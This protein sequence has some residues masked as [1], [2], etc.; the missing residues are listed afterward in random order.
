[1]PIILLGLLNVVKGTVL[2]MVV[3]TFTG[4][5]VKF[6]IVEVL[7]LLVRKYEIRAS[8]T[9]SKEDDVKAASCRNAL[10]FLKK[11]WK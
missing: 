9:P 1:M 2:K 5:A 3:A 4:E 10:E 7:E 8:K 11:T 6:A